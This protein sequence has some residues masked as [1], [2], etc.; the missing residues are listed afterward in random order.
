[1]IV[2]VKIIQ[3]NMV[4]KFL[5]RP[6]QVSCCSTNY[7]PS[8]NPR[9]IGLTGRIATGKSSIFKRLINKGAYPVDCDKVK[10]ITLYLG[11]CKSIVW[12][13]AFN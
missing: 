11:T 2:Y 12:T 7:H 3:N 13:P 8:H 5:L 10:K 6:K 4:V 1:M 9:L